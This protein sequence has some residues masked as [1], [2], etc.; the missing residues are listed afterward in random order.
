MKE[1]DSLEGIIRLY[2]GQPA[3]SDTE[4]KKI[5]EFIVNIENSGFMEQ[6]HKLISEK[7]KRTWRIGRLYFSKAAGLVFIL[8]LAVITTGF[9]VVSEYIRHIQVREKENYSIVEIETNDWTNIT[10]PNVIEDYNEP[11]WIPQEYYTDEEIKNPLVYTIIYASENGDQIIFRQYVPSVKMHYGAENGQ[12]EKVVFGCY[13]G[14]YIEA[15]TY[16]YLI[17]TDGMYLYSVIAENMDKET[18]IRMMY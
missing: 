11:V 14:E 10:E 12:H 13:S 2:Y 16:S 1:R 15:D 5:D 8:C 9:I 17:V 7:E 4:N 6:C 18:M 3:I